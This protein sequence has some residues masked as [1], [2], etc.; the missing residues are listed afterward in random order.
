MQTDHLIP[1]NHFCMQHNIESSFISM[2][3]DNGLIEIL[4]IEESAFIQEDNLPEI[5]KMMRLHYDLDINVEGIE[6]IIHLLR[7]IE[8]LQVEIVSLKNKL[9]MYESMD[10]IS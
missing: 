6:A 1:A 8:D 5:E 7:R 4:K 10:S 3:H 9:R 2:L